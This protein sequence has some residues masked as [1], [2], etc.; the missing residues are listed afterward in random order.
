MF[1]V[2]MRLHPF[3]GEA[4]MPTFSFTRK[5]L[6]IVSDDIIIVILPNNIASASREAISVQHFI[7]C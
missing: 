6:M 7:S 5:Y 3:Y 2:L 4:G 1:I